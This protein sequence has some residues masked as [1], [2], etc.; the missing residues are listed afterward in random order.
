M[1]KVA[2]VLA[3]LMAGFVLIPVGR[4]QTSGATPSGSAAPT[5]ATSGSTAQVPSSAGTPAAGAAPTGTVLP[6]VVVIGATPLLGSGVD[7]A[8][9]PAASQ[10]LTPQDITRYGPPQPLKALNDMVGGVALDE[11]A[12]NPLQPNLV[13]RGFVAGPLDGT[14]QGLAVYVNGARFN[15]PFGDTVNWDLIPDAAINTMNLEGANPVFGLNAL[16]GALNVQLKDG[17]S[18]HGSQFEIYGGSYGRIESDFQYGKQSGNTAAYIAGTVF[19]DGGWRD[20]QSTDQYNIYGDVGWRGDRA[21]LHLN[22]IAADTQLNGPGTIPVQLE[23]VQ[24]NA[25]FTGPNLVANKYT[26]ISLNGSYDITDTTSVQAVAYYQY[27]LQRVVNG[28]TPDFAPCD[29][30]SGFLCEDPGDFLTDRSGSP[31]PD[32]LNGGPYSE[33]DNQTVNT[34]GYGVSAQV[35]NTDPVF[36]LHN[37]FVAGASFDGGDTLFSAN[38]EVGGL[39]DDRNYAG[40]GPTIDQADGSIAPV[41]VGVTNGY[42][43]VFA[44]DILDVTPHLSLNAGGR[45]NY[46]QIDLDDQNGGDV[47]G[48]HSYAHFNPGVGLT[49]R[50]APALAVYASWSEANRAPTPAELSCADINSPCTLANFFVGDPNLKQVVARTIEAGLRG[51]FHFDARTEV[52]WNAGLFRTDSDDDIYFLPSTI[53]GRDFFQNIGQTRRQGVEAGISVRRGRLYAWLSYAYTDATFQ[54][55]FLEDSPLNPAA[56]ANGQI[57]VNKGDQLPGV[58]TN[59]LKFGVQYGVT[60]AWTVGLTGIASSG[61]FL[62]GDEANLTPKTGAY[63]VLG[64]NTN[65]KLTQHIE[66]FGLVQNMLNAK[67][68]TYGTFSDVTSVPIAQVPNATNTRSLSPAPPIAGYGGLRVTF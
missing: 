45:F 25:Q 8:K 16:G 49:Y 9:V 55:S 22:I 35:T 64:L 46:A 39:T 44:T 66:L 61:V 10:V 54:S 53:P 2:A 18:Y 52:Q 50:F 30:G 28:N 24:R 47:T 63:V 29:D 12:A 3:A 40:P 62:V 4:A 14:A 67:Y 56:D 20:E 17:F 7:Q 33:L 51:R 26:R 58:P 42:Y 1:R 38:S 37:H 19:H 60:P 15:M 6:P 59:R 13:Y 23:D 21:E 68:D 31:I 43:G 41:R 36:G 65:Y 34:N 48:N 27:L 5:S 57:Q 32:Y 11:A